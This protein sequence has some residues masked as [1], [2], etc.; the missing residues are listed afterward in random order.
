MLAHVPVILT[1]LTMRVRTRARYL[2][3]SRRPRRLWSSARGSAA[4]GDPHGCEWRAADRGDARRNARGIRGGEAD[5]LR[6]RDHKAAATYQHARKQEATVNGT[7]DGT[8]T[9]MQAARGLSRLC[10]LVNIG[11]RQFG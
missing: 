5:P 7:K 8:S 6:D 10:V 11:L 9:T 4:N 3:P 1:A 2:D